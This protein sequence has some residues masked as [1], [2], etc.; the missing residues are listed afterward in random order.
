MKPGRRASVDDQL[1]HTYTR[2]WTCYDTTGLDE[3]GVGV[4]LGIPIGS[5]HP[6]FPYARARSIEVSE[7]GDN[8]APATG[9][10]VWDVTVTYT[11]RFDAGSVTP[12]QVGTPP[13]ERVENPTL[14]APDINVTGDMKQIPCVID[15][16]K[17]SF[18][19]TMGD[20][21]LPPQMRTV[22]SVK[23]SVGRNFLL[24]PSG[25]FECVGK[26]NNARVTIPRLN[27]SIQARALKV[28]NASASPTYENGLF[29]WACKFTIELGTNLNL[30]TGAYLGWDVDLANMGK[31]FWND[32]AKKAQLITDELSPGQPVAEPRFLTSTNQVIRPIDEN[33]ATKPD[34]ERQIVWIRRKLDAE[35]DMTL[36]WR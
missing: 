27:W 2:S 28:T 5:S 26:V 29:Y 34:W 6:T 18:T 14:R 35:F 16:E 3:H 30:Y 8:G 36:L 23:I 4:A 22:P 10:A 19:N 1:I 33:G 21:L 7:N 13:E 20:P 24:F 17:R 25:L 11:N 12:Q 9:Y 15:Q 32:T 31:R